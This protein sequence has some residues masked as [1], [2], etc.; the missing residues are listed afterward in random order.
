MR[1]G[2]SLIE[3]LMAVAIMA[4]AFIPILTHSRTTILETEISQ[5][6]LLARHYLIDMVERYKGSTPDDLEPLAGAATGGPL[7]TDS[8]VV[9]KDPILSDHHRVAG[10]MQALE[11]ATGRK[12][13]GLQG[14]KKFLTLINMMKLTREASFERDVQPGVHRLTC[15]VRWLAAT[16]KSERKIE[17]TK[18]LVTNSPNTALCP[19]GFR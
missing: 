16:G 19:P 8:E 13:A 12:E 11:E 9:R 17:F 5:E 1:R 18:V 14:V 6:S 15:A 4:F 7:G 2:I 10:Q 3:I